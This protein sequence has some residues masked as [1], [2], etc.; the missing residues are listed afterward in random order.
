M[1][2]RERHLATPVWSR[3]LC[4]GYLPGVS[5][6][7]DPVLAKW[8]GQRNGLKKVENLIDDLLSISA[9]PPRLFSL[10][11]FRANR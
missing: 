2:Q 9:A 4:L 10:T 5:S 6:V 1:R 11:Q 8:H 7:S 3:L